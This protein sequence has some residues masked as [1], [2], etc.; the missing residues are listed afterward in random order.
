MSPMRPRRR[1]AAA[2]RLAWNER[3]TEVRPPSRSPLVE[4]LA[5]AENP[6]VR[7]P[8]I[9][10]AI[11]DLDPAPAVVT[12]ADPP[13]HAGFG[14]V[15]PLGPVIRPNPDRTRGARP[16]DRGAPVAEHRHEHPALRPV[17]ILDQ[18]PILIFLD[19]SDRQVAALV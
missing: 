13:D 3:D 12:L 10:L 14:Q 7:H 9:A 17:G 8:D 19:D 5:V 16:D 18:P 11:A 15:L 4:N 6:D 1:R 2:Y